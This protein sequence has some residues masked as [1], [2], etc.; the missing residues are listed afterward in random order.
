[1][2]DAT[3]PYLNAPCLSAKDRALEIAR[4]ALREI[5]WSNGDDAL[6]SIAWKAMHAI[7][8]LAPDAGEH[9]A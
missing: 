4:E 6:R 1:M 7:T 3:T 9:D 8:A 5:A 2:S